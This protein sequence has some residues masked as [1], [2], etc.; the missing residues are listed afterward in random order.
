[1]WDP[2]GPGLEPVC[3]ALAGGLLTTAPPGKP[4][5]TVLYVNLPK[6]SSR[7]ELELG[8]DLELLDTQAL[9]VGLGSGREGPGRSPLMPR[10]ERWEQKGLWDSREGPPRSSPD[11]G[12]SSA[13]T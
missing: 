12:P 2:P 4:S 13:I 11:F 8:P 10:P 7:G 3:P 1:M 6:D 5:S 9:L